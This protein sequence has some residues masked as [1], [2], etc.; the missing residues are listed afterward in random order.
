MQLNVCSPGVQRY[1]RYR[2]RGM[3]TEDACIYVGV[4]VWHVY[5]KTCTCG[6]VYMQVWACVYPY[7]GGHVVCIY[8]GVGVCCVST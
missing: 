7:R 6:R 4:G 8:V 5:R 3:W 2:C 1:I